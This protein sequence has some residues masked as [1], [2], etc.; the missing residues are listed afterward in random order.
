MKP[1]R[2]EDG[3]ADALP[4][5]ATVRRILAEALRTGLL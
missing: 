2:P 4:A 1:T 5:G 3:D